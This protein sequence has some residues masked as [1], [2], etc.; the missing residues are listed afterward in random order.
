MDSANPGKCDEANTEEN[1]STLVGFGTVGWRFD[2]AYQN[3]RADLKLSA[4][5]HLKEH[6]KPNLE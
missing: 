5:E 4:H 2:S 6:R 3:M 1:H